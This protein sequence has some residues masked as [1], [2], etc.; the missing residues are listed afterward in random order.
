MGFI[1][2]QPSS[3]SSSRKQRRTTTR[4]TTAVF[5]TLASVL[6]GDPPGGRSETAAQRMSKWGDAC[7]FIGSTPFPSSMPRLLPTRSN[8]L[9]ANATSGRMPWLTA[10]PN[11]KRRA[12]HC[13]VY[14]H[15]SPSPTARRGNA[16]RW[17]SRPE[18]VEDVTQQPAR[19]GSQ[20]LAI[21]PPLLVALRFA[22]Q[23]A[24]V[25]LTLA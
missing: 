9:P 13:F 22:P 10:E 2:Y 5:S 16:F 19:P 24:S 15:T 14:T 6:R 1:N 17:R 18:T 25:A 3:E 23:S 7:A 8:G 11:A 4:A 12:S 20:H 21:A